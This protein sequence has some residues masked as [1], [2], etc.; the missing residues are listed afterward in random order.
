MKRMLLA[1]LGM[2][3]LACGSAG[4]TNVPADAAPP[5]MSATSSRTRVAPPASVQQEQPPLADDHVRVSL[6]VLPGDAPVEVDGVLVRRRHGVV[7]L[8]G[9]VGE[10]RRV[11]VYRGSVRS[12]EKIVKIEATGA[13]PALIDVTEPAPVR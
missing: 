10:E 12:E 8:V 6:V 7:E 5:A 2:T 13:M 3:C 4:E 11:R 9:K 1:W